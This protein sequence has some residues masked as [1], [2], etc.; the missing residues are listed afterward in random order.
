MK[1]HAVLTADAQKLLRGQAADGLNAEGRALL[2][3]L[4][5]AG[6]HAI[7]VPRAVRHGIVTGE[8]ADPQLEQLRA[9]PEIASVE[10]DGTMRAI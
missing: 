3:R 7:N 9:L 10:V 5:S 4:G 2:G 1:V 8:L 6:L